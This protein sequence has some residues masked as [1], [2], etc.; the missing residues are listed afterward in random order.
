[1]PYKDPEKEK[2]YRE[3]HRKQWNKAHSDKR[4]ILL[5]ED[6][7]YREEWRR[8][9]RE[10][11]RRRRAQ[12]PAFRAKCNQISKESRIRKWTADP[13]AREKGMARSAIG[14]K[15]RRQE[16]QM[17]IDAFRVSGCV[18]CGEIVG[19]CLIAHHV[20]PK[21]KSFNIGTARSHTYSVEKVVAELKK[22]V[23]VCD[24]CHRKIHTGFFIVT[25]DRR[26][27]DKET[28]APLKAW[29]R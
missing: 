7:A 3:A 22:C 6:P 15:K 23:C 10:Y 17:V 4:R 24:N 5:K 2:A 27:V 18:R 25:P 29:Y 21:T 26:I 1:M 9:C 14:R 11:M 20:D 13:V 19:C 8:Q 28:E 12:D 16:I